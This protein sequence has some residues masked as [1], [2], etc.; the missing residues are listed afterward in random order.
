MRLFFP[1][2]ML[3]TAFSVATPSLDP[4]Q[5]STFDRQEIQAIH[6]AAQKLI[7]RRNILISHAA[8]RHNVNLK[9]YDYEIEKGVFFAKD[10]TSPDTTTDSNSP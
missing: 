9:E 4:I 7:D 8:K 10:I 3:L 2:T 6:S 5:V 1:L